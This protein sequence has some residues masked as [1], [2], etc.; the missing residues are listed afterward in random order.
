MTVLW[1]ILGLVAVGVLYY[2]S[3][4]NGIVKLKTTRDNAW[5]DI[6]VQLRMRF[7]LVDNLVNT[8]IKIIICFI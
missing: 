3:M 6:D 4:Y 8:V 2:I 5:S 1:V 7:D